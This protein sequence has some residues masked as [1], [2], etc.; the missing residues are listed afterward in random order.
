MADSGKEMEELR[1]HPRRDLVLKVEYDNVEKFL[2]D[3][4]HNI[5]RG[6]I[7]IKTDKPLEKGTILHF[8]ISFPGILEPLSL[9][10]EVAWRKMALTGR[11]EAESLGMG[12]R[13]IFDDPASKEKIDG[14]VERI[15]GVEGADPSADKV[16]KILLVDDNPSLLDMFSLGFT[17][18]ENTVVFKAQDGTE[19]L[20]CMIEHDIDL[21][22]AD[23]Y[24]PIMDGF[25]FIRLIRENSYQKR[26][27]IIA[28]SAGGQGMR[29]KCIEAGADFYIDKPITLT[30]LLD[31]VRRLLH[32]KRKERKP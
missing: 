31:T 7:F 14:I 26:V 8:Q 19:A 21:I 3:Y 20:Q 9:R 4:T 6:G 10:G 1:S 16:L 15:R 27:P 23:I 25:Q 30:K 32:I 17:Q 18:L 5:S 22:I 11:E 29:E 12:V 24:M 2:H 13:F 28:I